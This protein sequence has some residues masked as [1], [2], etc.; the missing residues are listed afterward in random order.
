MAT[1]TTNKQSYYYLNHDEQKKKSLRNYYMKQLKNDNLND[2]Q[3]NKY[4]SKL[5]ELNIELEEVDV[6]RNNKKI[7]ED[8]R[9][10]SL[11]QYYVKQLKNPNINT[12]QRNKYEQRLD[13]LNRKINNVEELNQLKINYENK[14]K[15]INEMKIKY[16]NKLQEINDMINKLSTNENEE[17][18]KNEIIN[19]IVLN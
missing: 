4:E 9:L 19:N 3:R 1:K 16:E 6:K 14:L 8:K 10:K 11:R 17:E 15:T 13:E 12:E 5:E 18:E 7:D 2:E